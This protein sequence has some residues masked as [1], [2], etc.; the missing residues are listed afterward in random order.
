MI[1][2]ERFILN[3]LVKRSLRQRK[4]KFGYGI[5]GMAT[6]MRTYS[7]MKPD[8]S[9][10]RWADTVIRCV[11]GVLSI[12]KNHYKV[13]N[14]RWD[15]DYWQTVGIRMAN[16]IFDIK[17]LPPGRSLWIMGSEYIYERGAAGLYNC[18]YISVK[19]LSADA[20]AIMD[21]LMCVPDDTWVAT[22]MG[23]RQVK[24]LIDRPFVAMVGG[25]GYFSPRG[26][27]QTG[28]ESLYR[29]EAQGA[30]F[31][32]TGNHKVHTQDGWKR[33]D[34]LVLGDQISLGD[35]GLNT[36]DGSGTEEEGYLLGHLIGDGWFTERGAAEFSLYEPEEEL[37]DILPYLAKA[38][39]SLPGRADRVGFRRDEKKKAWRLT[40]QQVGILAKKFGMTRGHKRVT[41]EIEKAS[42]EFYKGFLSGVFDTDGTAHSTTKGRFV[43]LKWV[44]K[45]SLVSVQR[46]LL[47]FGIKGAIHLA[48]E[49]GEEVF[50]EKTAYCQARWEL[51]I[52]GENRER[53]V[54]LVGFKNT[55]KKQR[56]EEAIRKGNLSA[57]SLV[58]TAITE[59]LEQVPVYDTVVEGAH[60]FDGNGL[61]LHNCG[62]GLGFDTF[63]CTTNFKQPREEKEIYVIPDT[64]EGWVEATRRLIASYEEGTNTIEFDYSKIRAAGEPIKGFGGTASGS[65]PLE[66]LH[67]RI[68]DGCERRLRGESSDVR[69]ITDIVNQVAACVV[70]GNVRRSALIALGKP[71]DTEFL[72]LKDWRK[73]EN[74]ERMDWKTGWG[75]TSNNSVVL[76]SAE[77]FDYLP[78][79]AHRVGLN[80]EP[81]VLNLMNVQKYGRMGHK[82]RDEA[83]GINPCG[84]IPL[85]SYE[86]CNLSEVF[87][88][89]CKTDAEFFEALELATIY[90]SSVTL[91]QTHNQDTNAV[92]AKNRRIGVSISGIPDWMASVER[93][94]DIVRL[95]NAGYELVERTNL[96]LAIEAGVP[97]SVRLTTVKPSGTI[98]LLA[99]VSPGMHHPIFQTY[100]RRVKFGVHSPVV[101]LLLEAGVP[102]EP[103]DKDPNNTLSFEF[104]IHMKG[105]RA[106][107]Q[108]SLA[109]HGLRLILI[110]RFWTDNAASNTSNFRGS[111][112][113]DESGKNVPFDFNHPKRPL[114]VRGEEEEIESWLTMVIP[115]VKSSSMLPYYNGATTHRQMPYEEISYEEFET[116]RD[117]IADIDWTRFE[118][119]DGEDSRY[120]EG[121]SCEI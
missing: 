115:H 22:S 14:L 44:D 20:S 80:G 19:K 34:K 103:D 105:V 86:T 104:P 31:R 110:S 65:G 36:W 102:Y 38:V 8:G 100:V 29:I 66:L 119:S 90:S 69:L 37:T 13:N 48:A 53:F 77:D 106:Q 101:P 83:Q 17:F 10:E 93:K 4:E 81:G 85:E 35:P 49:A 79:I 28:T 92:I 39:L 99:G 71:S 52:T 9:Q 78:D 121:V 118:G 1:V 91:L 6:Y 33:T 3:P 109:E 72:D 76:E 112:Y 75:H 16:A 30:T 64:R 25:V 120:C 41:P 60:A 88:T 40:D 68:R 21:F 2:E 87:P 12:R 46:M 82:K 47:R 116:R 57:R 54:E 59:E 62:I 56:S 95:L 7:R 107:N 32:A 11:E 15:E 73:P 63:S 26:F 97:Q 117:A 55:K 5:L 67:T 50:G 45:E 108:V 23:P 96:R 61:L 89:R 24:D 43:S 94:S 70:A 42:S 84:E 113:S 51:R 111:L 27:F 18:A 114:A 74:A 58:V 98:S